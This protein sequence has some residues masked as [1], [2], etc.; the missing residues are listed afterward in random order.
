MLSNELRTELL[1]HISDTH[2]IDIELKTSN[3]TLTCVP[4]SLGKTFLIILRFFD[5]MPDGFVV[6]P[7]EQIVSVT[8]TKTNAFFEKI[9]KSEGM[10]HLV[11]EVPLIGLDKWESVLSFF[12]ASQEI[13]VVDIGHE[14][15]VNVGIIANHSSTKI[16]M[17]C[18]SPL[19]EWD[20]ENWFEPIEN[21]TA[22][23]F[24]TH[25]TKTFSKFFGNA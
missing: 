2:Y 12:E 4:V 5:F 14:N 25:Y 16:E 19:G 6:V 10:E 21:I 23:S 11:Y 7:V 22:I 9:I 15:C 24:R 17:K 13:V 3:E 1:M 18:F 20:D 8:Y